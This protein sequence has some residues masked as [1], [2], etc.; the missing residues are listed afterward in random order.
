MRARHASTRMGF[1]ADDARSA[2]VSGMPLVRRG[3]GTHEAWK[4]AM[5][6]NGWIEGSKTRSRRR[7]G[8]L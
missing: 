8:L 5:L 4:A 3:A 7:F 1:A 2:P 6:S